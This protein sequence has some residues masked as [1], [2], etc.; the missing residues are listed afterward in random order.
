MKKVIAVF[1]LII[2]VFAF[3]GC[4]N[5]IALIKQQP[6]T[7]QITHT[8]FVSGSHTNFPYNSIYH[9]NEFSDCIR[10]TCFTYGSF[11]QII[12]DGNPYIGLKCNIDKP[13][14]NVDKTKRIQMANDNTDK[15]KSVCTAYSAKSEESDPLAAIILAG[16]YL[17]SKPGADSKQ[18][19]ICDSLLGTTGIL[20][21]IELNFFEMDPDYVVSELKRLNALPDLTD[22]EVEIFGAGQVC[23]NQDKLTPDYKT[24][25]IQLWDTIFESSNASAV[26]F[27]SQ[28]LDTEN[29]D[30]TGLPFVS[31]V[32]IPHEGIE[33][34]DT[35]GFDNES[36]K[37]KPDSSSILDRD[38]AVESL[39][40]VNNYLISHPYSK[41]TVAGSTS[42]YGTG[43]GI[44]LSY[45]RANA[46]KELLVSE[47][48]IEESRISV[49][50]LGKKSSPFRVDDLDQDGN[51]NSMAA[52]NRAIF[53]YDSNS[54][55]AKSVQ[56]SLKSEAGT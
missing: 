33:N 56:R 2:S 42:S 46:I 8:A 4:T 34:N 5:P 3:T 31:C 16:E 27:N 25:H 20:N 54:D 9:V 19:V 50:G 47:Y 49:L 29:Y 10:T 13:S 52:A 6:E 32:Y 1:L 7:E 48:G 21:N 37:F 26:H 51:L 35:W 24:K 45:E 43:D 38:K 22:C 30:S 12:V 11:A 39:S 17:R 41:I 36:I 44:D 53:I 40:T 18:L 55:C 14:V 28:P 23:G 15:I